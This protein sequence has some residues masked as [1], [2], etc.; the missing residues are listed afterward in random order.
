MTESPT[1]LAFFDPAQ[2]LHG[3][4]R[5]GLT[6]LF[7]GEST[8]ALPEGPEVGKVEGGHRASVPGHFDVT[9]TRVGPEVSLGGE[10]ISVCRV[11]GSVGGRRVECVGTA[12]DVDTPP[13]WSELDALRTVSA[14]FD[15]G[16]AVLAVAR[17]PRGAPGHGRELVSAALLADGEPTSVEEARV[18][19]VYDGDARQRSAG[20]EL[21]LPG[22]AFPRRVSGTVSAGTTLGLEGLRVN[23]AIFAWQ[24]EG[25]AGAG[26]Y[27]IAVRDEPEAA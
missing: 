5:V 10:R 26:A 21:W 27:E 25:R 4:W 20:L 8:T 17:R 3:I 6:L 13:P 16:D 14:L 7:D 19:T 15:E 22:E 23:V 2:R 12:T 24:M 1:A 9:F 11:E 18:S